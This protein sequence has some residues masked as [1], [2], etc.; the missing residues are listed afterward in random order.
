MLKKLG[1]IMVV[2]LAVLGVTAGVAA[3]GEVDLLVQKLVDKGVLTPN[4]AQILMDETKQDVARQNAKGT[5]DAI[6]TWVQTTKLKGD[7]RLRQELAQ[8]KGSAND[9][10]TRIR[11]RLGVET[12]PNDQM[13]VGIGIA[14]GKLS[15]PRSTNVSFGTDSSASNANDPGSFKDVTLDYAFGQFTPFNGVTLTGGKFKNPLWQPNDMLWDTD[16]NPEGGAV[17]LNGNLASGVDVFLNSSI[18]V[19]NEQRTAKMSEP[20]LLAVQPGLAW[21]VADGIK[22]QGALAYYNFQQIQ[23]RPK[24]TKQ[25]TNSLNGSNYKYNYNSINPSLELGI[26]NPLGGLVPYFSIFADYVKNLSLPG[27]VAG[28]SGFDYGVKFGNEKVG[29]WGQWQAKL[30]YDRL[31]RDAFLDIFPDSDRYNGKTNMRSYEAL[32]EYGL[33][34]NTSLA[35]DYYRSESLTRVGE[36]YSPQ[37]VVQ[38]DWNLKF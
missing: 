27:S 23:E 13:K 32:L 16:L 35:L 29:D 6:P 31:G 11:M 36:T 22:L 24:F 3:A 14:T 4:E 18:F 26:Q 1:T 20:W 28:G 2:G 34:K 17:Q 9:N 21:E 38:V 5:N 10:R 7:F 37:Q 12:K 8:D 33:G 25:S 19:M 15:D 30:S